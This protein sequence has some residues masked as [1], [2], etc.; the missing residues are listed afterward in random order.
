[1]SKEGYTKIKKY[2]VTLSKKHKWNVNIED[3]E[4][5]VYDML[6][7][8]RNNI[9]INKKMAELGF[10]YI[11]NVMIP[12]MPT[13]DGNTI[14]KIIEQSKIRQFI[15][16]GY[17]VRDIN[18]AYLYVYY[19]IINKIKST[20]SRGCVYTEARLDAMGSLL[21]LLYFDTDNQLFAGGLGSI[22]EDTLSALKHYHCADGRYLDKFQNNYTQ[23]TISI[24]SDIIK[25]E[26]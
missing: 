2:L 14:K 7:R 11:N 13:E 24:L 10:R 6:N 1:M 8:D 12:N 22:R 25:G 4:Y 5:D 20:Y 23:E 17:Y 9:Y 15:D 26:K 16:D 21:S 18:D 19:A 3:A